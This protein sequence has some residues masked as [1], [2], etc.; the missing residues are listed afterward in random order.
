MSVNPATG[1][2][3]VSMSKPIGNY[4]IKVIGTLPDLATLNSAIFTI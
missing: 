4:I 3:F 1:S 2:I